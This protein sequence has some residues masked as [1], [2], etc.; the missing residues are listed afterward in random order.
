MPLLLNL[1]LP[2]MYP[3]RI[4]VA[5]MMTMINTIV[6]ILLKAGLV[7]FLEARNAD[8]CLG[9]RELVVPPQHGLQV[10]WEYY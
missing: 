7:A 9:R 8:K 6:I 1:L 4:N 3:G 10:R 2:A 5:M